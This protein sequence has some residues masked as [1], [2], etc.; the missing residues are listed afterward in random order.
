MNIKNEQMA[1]AFFPLR[2][3]QAP[4]SGFTLIELLVVI[5]IIAI[6]AAMLLPALAKAKEKARGIACISNNRQIGLGLIMYAGD[7]NDFLPPV[8]TV[9]WPAISANWWFKIIDNGKYL[10]ASSKSNNVWRCTAVQDADIA[11]GTVNYYQSPCE[12]YGPLE[13]NTYTAGVIRYPKDGSGNPLGSKR[14]A[15]INRS[16]QIWLVGDVGTFKPTFTPADKMPPSYNTEVTTKQP[17]TVP[18]ST[19]GT[20]WKNAAAYKQPAARHNGRANFSFCDGHVESW[21]W[22]DL[23]AD[24]NDVFAIQSY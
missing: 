15:Q 11:P 18:D 2:H 7:N 19:T 24:K 3:Q 13:G 21:K 4:K 20:G 10:T 6:L 23:R 9:T 8:N 1:P 22:T 5:A 16:S 12:G 14:L 17:D